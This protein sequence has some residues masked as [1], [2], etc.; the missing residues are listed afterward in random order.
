MKTF[1][2]HHQFERYLVA[3]GSFF[4]GIEVRRDDASGTEVQ[5]L[6]V[7]IEYGPKE[8]WLARLVQDPDFKQGVGIIV[9]RMAYEITGI[10]YEGERHLNSLNTMTFPTQE[11]G[12][13]AR[14]YVGVS[15]NLNLSLDI[16]VKLQQDGFQIVEQ[17]FPY[18]TPDLTFRMQ[19]IEELG[20]FDQIPLT[21]TSVSCADNYDGDFEHRRAIIWSLGFSM[22]VNFYGPVRNQ[23][24]IDMVDINIFNSPLLST[25][26]PPAV[27]AV[28]NGKLFELEDGSGHLLDESSDSSSAVP[29]VHINVTATP[30]QEP[31]PSDNVLSTTTIT[32]ENI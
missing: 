18:F 30:G 15:Y 6:V 11:A 25:L 13:L 32:E 16:L 26:S 29:T 31:I 7:P 23:R 14:L 21:L 9:P 12:Q 4:S 10:N 28:E 1:F 24:R 5:R 2:N 3:F 22:K 19:P 27:L 8:R 17:I 20:F